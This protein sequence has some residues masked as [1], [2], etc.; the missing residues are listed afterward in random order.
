MEGGSDDQD[1]ASP[2][3]KAKKHGGQTSVRGRAS[4][5]T[6]KSPEIEFRAEVTAENAVHKKRRTAMAVD[7]TKRGQLRKHAYVRRREMFA[8]PATTML[9]S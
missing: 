7:A 3:K 8:G 1:A 4:P 9:F 2:P 5:L 6:T